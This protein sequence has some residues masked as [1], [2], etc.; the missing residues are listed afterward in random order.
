LNNIAG[1]LTNEMLRILLSHYGYYTTG[2]KE[3]LLGD[4][5][6]Y[7]EKKFSD[8]KQYLSIS[9]LKEL[10]RKCVLDA[11]SSRKQVLIKNLESKYYLR[12]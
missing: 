12:I 6:H 5:R 3:S 7:R 1:L 4:Y 8:L 10:N 9:D 2:N 11:N